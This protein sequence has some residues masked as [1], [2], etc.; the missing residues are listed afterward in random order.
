MYFV[1]R[2]GLMLDYDKIKDGKH[3]Y[4]TLEEARERADERSRKT[5]FNFVVV[6]VEAVY[7]TTNTKGN[8]MQDN[9]AALLDRNMA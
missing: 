4:K 3:G 1:T 6:K 9:R 5:G 7:E 8:L 2:R